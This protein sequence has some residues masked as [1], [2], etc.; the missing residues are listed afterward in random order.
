MSW[1]NYL[2]DNGIRI[3]NGRISILNIIE[4]ST[5]GLAADKIYSECK[6]NNKNI[7]LSTIYRTLEMLEEKNILKKINID[8]PAIFVLKKEAHMHTLRCD[9]CNKSVEIQCPMEEIEES[10]KTQAGF[11]LTE[12]KLELKGICD[13]C[14]NEKN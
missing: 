8:G 4:S 6:K 7:N 5:K 14:K 11:S 2:K 9:M 12:H 10:I 3:T 13:K 1:E